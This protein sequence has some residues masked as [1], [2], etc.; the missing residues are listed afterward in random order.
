MTELP[1]RDFPW[2]CARVKTAMARCVRVRVS[3]R[4][5]RPLRSGRS[6]SSARVTFR[7]GFNCSPSLRRGRSLHRRI[8]RGFGELDGVRCECRRLERPTERGEVHINVIGNYITG[9]RAGSETSARNSP[10]CSP[11]CYTPLFI[12]FSTC[13]VYI[14]AFDG[15]LSRLAMD[16]ACA[17]PTT[18]PLKRC[19]AHM[20]AKLADKYV[21]LR[22]VNSGAS[23]WVAAADPF[24]PPTPTSPPFATPQP[25][26]SASPPSSTTAS[27]SRPPS[28]PP[29][30]PP[31][32]SPLS[33][34]PGVRSSYN[35]TWL[36]SWGGGGGGG[37]REEGRISVAW[38]AVPSMSSLPPY[39]LQPPR[40]HAQRQLKKNQP[41]NFNL[42]PPNTNPKEAK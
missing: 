2:K 33:F 42:K 35:P 14:K 12:N 31:F 36:R 5:E 29:P 7:R 21:Y 17:G 18:R 22:C 37:R 40:S 16:R 32:L 13:V 10:T 25:H 15:F 9:I 4:V 6:G 39:T 8:I 41:Q 23:L 27:T 34:G 28:L 38:L 30:S 19:A 20:L 3:R 26:P 11:H 1:L 24:L